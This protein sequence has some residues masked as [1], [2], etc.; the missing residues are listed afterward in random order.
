MAFSHP[1]LRK[2]IPSQS[3]ATGGLRDILR[4]VFGIGSPA[5]QL[6]SPSQVLAPRGFYH[7]HEG[8]LFQPGTQNWV[9]DPSLETPLQ[10]N[11]GR[12]FLRTPNVFNPLQ[13]PQVYSHANI[14]TNGLGGQIAGNIVLQP[15]SENQTG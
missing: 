6:S 8:D 13:P 15:L 7:L 9:L 3:V 5:A 4:G 10:T 11:W 12:G 2:R 1:A 14:K